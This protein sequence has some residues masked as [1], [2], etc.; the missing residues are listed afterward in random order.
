MKKIIIPIISFFSVF[1]AHGVVKAEMPFI[2]F[3]GHQ[4]QAKRS[5]HGSHASHYSGVSN[6]SINKNLIEELFL[7]DSL[8]NE[9]IKIISNRF[10][11]PD[12]GGK[13]CWVSTLERCFVKSIDGFELNEW[14]YHLVFGISR[15]SS[16]NIHTHKCYDFYIP[17][18]SDYY[19]EYRLESPKPS[20]RKSLED[21]PW[22]VSIKN[23]VK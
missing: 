15:I 8:Q 4:D 14:C 17:E 3:Q 21:E 10:C 12:S 19:V 22:I 7:T 18:K 13:D 5:I 9:I 20:I 6:H 23:I 11:N 1:S 16:Q 2:L